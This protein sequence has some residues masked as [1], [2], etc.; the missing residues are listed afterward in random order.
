MELKSKRICSDYTEYTING[1]VLYMNEQQRI[2]AIQ[3]IALYYD[4]P[5][6]MFNEIMTIAGSY[7][8][9]ENIDLKTIRDFTSKLL[10]DS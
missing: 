7:I 4:N 5:N 3:M 9:S 10:L 6:H 2:D 1:E 8:R